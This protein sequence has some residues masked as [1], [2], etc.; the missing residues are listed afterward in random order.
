ML[1]ARSHCRS[2][3][4][5][6]HACGTGFEAGAA[7]ASASRAPHRAVRACLLHTLRCGVAIEIA[8]Q[9]RP[10]ICGA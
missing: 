5:G 7:A 4:H 1:L 8:R 2:K 6:S 10:K 9:C 3:P